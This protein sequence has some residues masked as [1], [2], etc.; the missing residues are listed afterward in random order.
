[1]G[2]HTDTIQKLY[3]AYFSRPADAGGLAFWEGIVAAAQGDTSAVT[4]AFA[5][6]Q[7][8]R[9]TYAGRTPVEVVTAVYR[10][11]FNR[12]PEPVGLKFWADGLAARL[13]T[14][15][16]AVTA[17]AAGAQGADLD[18]FNNKVRAGVAFTNALDHHPEQAAYQGEDAIAAAKAFTSTITDNAS[19][20]SALARLDA[21]VAAFVAASKASISFTLSA[22]ADSGIA[23]T[24]GGGNDIYHATGASFNAGDELNGGGGSNQLWIT[25]DGALAAQP[26]GVKLKNVAGLSIV[27]KGAVGAAQPWDASGYEGLM[28]VHVKT[29]G[30]TVHLNTGSASQASVEGASGTVTV[31]GNALAGL[32][33]LADAALKL[34]TTALAATD[35]LASLTIG[36]TGGVDADL[37]GILP[38]AR[39]DASASAGDHKLVVASATALSV[40]GGKGAEHLVLTGRLH[41]QASIA[42]GGGNDRYDFSAAAAAGARV[43]GGAGED[44]MVVRD[45]ALLDTDG[46]YTGFEVLDF[47]SGHGHYDLGRAGSVTALVASARLGDDE[48]VR[49]NNGRAGSSISFYSTANAHLDFENDVVFAL[50]DSSGAVDQLRISLFAVDG[51]QDGVARG[52]VTARSVEAKGIEE[53]TLV[54]GVV[55]GEGGSYANAISYL[56]VDDARTVILGGSAKLDMSAIYSNRLALIDASSASG[57][58]TLSAAVTTDSQNTLAYTY[59][60]SAGQDFVYGSEAGTV[61][62]GNAGADTI[63]LAR[64]NGRDVIRIA[65]ATDSVLVIGQGSN[66]GYDEVAFFKGGEDQFDL[67]MLQLPSGANRGAIT[68]HKLSADNA[69]N[70]AALVANG[71]GFFN[72]GGS[73]RSLAWANDGGDGYL[74]I[75][76]NA[77]GNYTGGI[78]T[79]IHILGSA[80]LSLAD[81][82]FA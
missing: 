1:M 57:D 2:I 37:S 34:D 19:V 15:D 3:V 7:E 66:G 76:I 53:I 31:G 5:N 35:K 6:S 36:G 49:F 43:D 41:N 65:K 80:N 17:I 63:I 77:D 39:V 9:D 27:A 33:I 40:S 50:K 44:T 13:F 62:Q 60:G 52:S 55:N 78:D 24:G 14:V 59:L 73:N 72:D 45:G 71:A 74:F 32:A 26:A 30:G 28:S 22:N 67:S 29:A 21:T 18:T 23:F 11:L 42:L 48:A 54:S 12:D 51:S 69:P 47:S 79:A 64:E 81:F 10:N 38:L 70:I 4:A 25:A 46:I 82:K 16:V 61:F 8:Y 68:I 58:F 20:D 75:D 56:H